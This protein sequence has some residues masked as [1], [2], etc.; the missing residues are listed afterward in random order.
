MHVAPAGMGT[1]AVG[2]ILFLFTV[3]EGDG[4]QQPRR[5]DL[6]AY[7]VV[8]A[9][10]VEKVRRVPILKQQLWLLSPIQTVSASISVLH[11]PRVRPRLR[12]VPVSSIRTECMCAS[13]TIHLVMQDHV[14]A[15]IL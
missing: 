1:L 8:S 3:P 12:E 7:A 11:R 15:A 13:G 14:V 2:A 5:H 4:L 9:N 10:R 6:A